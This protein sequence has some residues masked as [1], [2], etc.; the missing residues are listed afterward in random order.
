MTDY[1]KEIKELRRVGAGFRAGLRCLFGGCLLL[2]AL[3]LL[4]MGIAALVAGLR[5]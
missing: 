5:L 4:A 3:A 2:V 1:N